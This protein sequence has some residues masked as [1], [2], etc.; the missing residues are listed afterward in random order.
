MEMIFAHIIFFC[1][2]KRRIRCSQFALQWPFCRHGLLIFYQ[3]IWK[4]I[5]TVEDC[6]SCSDIHYVMLCHQILHFLLAR[7]CSIVSDCY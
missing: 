3:V 5:V 1:V 6:Q 2:L 4:S 7:F